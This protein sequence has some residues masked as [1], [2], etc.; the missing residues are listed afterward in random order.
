MPWR[1]IV[2][3][4]CEAVV[5]VAGTLAALTNRFRLKEGDAG[6]VHFPTTGDASLQNTACN[7]DIA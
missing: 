1:L 7:T 5:L 3:Y 6:L 2:R 4:P